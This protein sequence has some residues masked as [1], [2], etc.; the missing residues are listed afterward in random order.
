MRIILEERLPIPIYELVDQAVELYAEHGGPLKRSRDA[1]NLDLE[2]FLDD[3]LA[4][5]LGRRGLSYDEIAAA[6]PGDVDQEHGRILKIADRANALHDVRGDASFLAVVLAAKRIANI[7]KGQPEYLLGDVREPAEVALYEAHQRLE[8][9]VARGVAAG[10]VVGYAGALSAI[11]S[12]A[13]PLERFFT[14]VMV[15]VDDEAVRRNRLALLQSI[16]RTLSRVARL[17]E[18]VVEKAE[19]R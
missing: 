9:E 16:G 10:G 19:Y 6:M 18:M 11:A 3:R 15:M 5:L 1:I 7:T 8:F 2:V 14:D 13:D 12:L 4:F 17:T